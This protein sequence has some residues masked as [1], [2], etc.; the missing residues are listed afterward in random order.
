MKTVQE[1][2]IAVIVLIFPLVFAF[3]A[4]ENLRLTLPVRVF[5][6]KQP[7]TH[8]QEQDFQLTINHQQREILKAVKKTASLDQRPDFLGRNFVLS[9]HITEYGNQVQ[10]AISYFV[11]EILDITD[12][13]ILMTPL[14]IYRINVSPNKGKMKTDIDGLVRQDSE[15]FKKRLKAAE[16]NLEIQLNRMRRLFRGEIRD[17]GLATSYKIIGTFLSSFPQGFL[18]FR[19]LFLFPDMMN[20]QKVLGFLGHREGERWWVHFQQGDSFEVVASTQSVAKMID[21]YCSL[22]TLARESFQN[23]LQQLEKLLRLSRSFPA[24]PLVHV[25]NSGNIRY[26]TILWVQRK[27]KGRFSA[28]DIIPILGTVL[29][30]VSRETGGKTVNTT[31]PEQGIKTI[32]HHQDRYYQ[33]TYGFNGSIKEKKIDVTAVSADL[34]NTTLSYQHVYS[35]EEMRALIRELSKKSIHIDDFSLNKNQI[36]FSIGS[37]TLNK[38]K[39]GAFGLVKVRIELFNQTG[40]CAYRTENTLRSSKQQIKVSIPLPDRHK[41]KFKLMINACD[42]IANQLA[43]FDQEVVL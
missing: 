21:E 9:F 43:S 25:F 37:V 8:L 1:L 23:N 42:I 7:V 30:R 17:P 20:Y 12:S 34:K 28:S 3:T 19:S 14:K 10:E 27:H 24:D 29:E 36:K 15:E 35:E 6:G 32:H 38:N 5:E 40:E 16:K 41:G 39:G 11:T 4:E 31:D 26:N 2:F 18:N 22:Y 13:L 33:L